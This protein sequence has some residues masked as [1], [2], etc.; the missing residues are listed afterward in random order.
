M[1]PAVRWIGVGFIVA[2]VA[3]FLPWTRFGRGSGM[4][5]AWNL[6]WSGAAAIA[7]ALG[8]LAWILTAARP[9]R[10]LGRGTV[11]L[12]LV[13]A[14]VGVT[15][16]ALALVRPPVF[17]RPWLG[18]W[19]ALAGGLLALGASIAAWPNAPVGASARRRVRVG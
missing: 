3:T 4:F 1:E 17:A 8:T 9:S 2:G 10:P 12:L 13:I 6:T 18:L 15:T 7:F 19:I 14:A 11:R 5:G 16:T